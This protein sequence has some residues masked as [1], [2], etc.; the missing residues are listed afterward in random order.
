MHKNA[1][2]DVAFTLGSW[3]VESL[4]LIHRR[5]GEIYSVARL[6]RNKGFPHVLGQYIS[7]MIRLGGTTDMLEWTCFGY[8]GMRGNTKTNEPVASAHS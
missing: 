6:L 3:W 1:Y 7:L 2:D 5:T 4:D 8:L